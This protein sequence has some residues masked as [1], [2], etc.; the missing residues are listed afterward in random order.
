M[1][2]YKAFLDALFYWA[3][4]LSCEEVGKGYL[5]SI[6][7]IQRYLSF[8]YLRVCL[9][10]PPNSEAPGKR[11]I[12]CFHPSGAFL[13]GTYRKIR[14]PCHLRTTPFRFMNLFTRPPPVFL[15]DCD[16]M[17]VFYLLP[18]SLTP[19]SCLSHLNSIILVMRPVEM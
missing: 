8:S 11:C 6:L 15:L 16:S 14:K 4:P 17:S 13:P 9:L 3:F 12:V 2:C 10:A 7:Q 1:T 5:T 18:E 19:A